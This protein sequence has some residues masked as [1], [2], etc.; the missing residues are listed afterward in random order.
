M[1]KKSRPP[2]W[3]VKTHRPHGTLGM[4]DGG[5]LCCVGERPQ[6]TLWSERVQRED[7]ASGEIPLRDNESEV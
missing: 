5:L 3:S 6:A 1:G 2:G 4:M 7:I